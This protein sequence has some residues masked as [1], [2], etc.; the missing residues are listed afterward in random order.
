MH[1]YS[2][3]VYCLVQLF[4]LLHHYLGR[5]HGMTQFDINVDWPVLLSPLDQYPWLAGLHVLV[6]IA[7][8]AEDVTNAI[9][10]PAWR[11]RQTTYGCAM[12]NFY[13]VPLVV[14]IPPLQDAA[15]FI[16]AIEGSNRQLKA[17][18]PH[19]D[20]KTENPKASIIIYQNCNLP[21]TDACYN[22]TILM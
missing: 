3:A 19:A 15:P 6:A 20:P 18:C 8:D 16:S 1:K 21:W 12:N 17:K 14:L 2:E 22:R 9:S 13:F 5:L 10:Q 7:T 4:V 11:E